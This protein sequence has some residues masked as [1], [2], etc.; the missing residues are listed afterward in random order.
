M[1]AEVECTHGKCCQLSSYPEP[2]MF[3]FMCR[4][5][6]LGLK[7]DYLLI[8]LTY[9]SVASTPVSWSLAKAGGRGWGGPAFSFIGL[10]PGL[11][12]LSASAF[13]LSAAVTSVQTGCL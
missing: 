8:Y 3:S 6:T 11:L 2:R 9:T 12:I 7:P 10:S 1:G 13:L 5:K 4:M